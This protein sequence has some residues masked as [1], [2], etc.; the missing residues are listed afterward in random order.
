MGGRAGKTVSSYRMDSRLFM[1]VILTAWP[2]GLRRGSAA[3]RLLG[4]RV[5]IQSLAW[6]SVSC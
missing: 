3:A 6:M 5:R 1:D 2:R 4:P